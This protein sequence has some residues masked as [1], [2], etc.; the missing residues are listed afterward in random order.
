MKRMR[1]NKYANMYVYYILH[2]NVSL[3]V[4]WEY[5][6]NDLVIICLCGNISYFESRWEAK[7]SNLIW[8]FNEHLAWNIRNILLRKN[9]YNYL[10]QYDNE[11]LFGKM[12]L[13]ISTQ[14]KF[15]WIV[16]VSLN[17]KT[18]VI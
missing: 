2:N 18:F 15:S 11:I 8:T 3:K 7:N 6:H 9:N 16:F 4:K 14:I 10:L 13:V 12:R 1:R 5:E 17:F